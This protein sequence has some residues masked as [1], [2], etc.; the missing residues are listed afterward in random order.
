MIPSFLELERRCYYVMVVLIPCSP[1]SRYIWSRIVY[2]LIRWWVISFLRGSPGSTIYVYSYMRMI[3]EQGATLDFYTCR[4]ISSAQWFWQV[5]QTTVDV[6]RRRS[7]V[8]WLACC[9]SKAVRRWWCAGLMPSATD[10]VLVSGPGTS[11]EFM[12]SPRSW[13]W[14]T[15]CL[16]HCNRN[17]VRINYQY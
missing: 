4:V 3:N 10:L 13:R 8:L 7:S 16:I 17:T 6:C 14:V 1:F 11:D 15:T 2:V 12:P 5:S 9:P